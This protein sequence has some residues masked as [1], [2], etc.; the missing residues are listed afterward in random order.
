MSEKKKI[1][2]IVGTMQMGGQ[3]TFIMNIFR[4]IDREKYEFGFVVHS[5]E[6]AY[7]ED[8]VEKL[9][10]KIYRI[11]SISK[12]PIKHAMQLRTIINQN[13]F[14]IMHRHT[15]TSIVFI[16]LLIGRLCRMKKVI[17]HSHSNVSSKFKTIHKIFR[18]LLNIFAT[19]KL[20]CSKEAGYWLYGK[21]QKFIIVP[22]S[23]DIDKFKYNEEKRM[24]IRKE[25]NC[26]NKI[27]LGHIGRFDKIKN[28]TFLV[29][30]FE[31]IVEKNKN[32]ELWFLGNGEEKENIEK[33]C[34]EKNIIDSVKF[35]GTVKDTYNFLQGMDLFVFPS[36]KEGLGIALI[37]AQV[38]G[39][40]CVVSDTIQKEAIISKNVIQLSIET[41]PE[42]WAEIILEEIEKSKNRKREIEKVVFKKYDI[43]ELVSKIE[44]IYY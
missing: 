3:E 42:K 17:V 2:H 10:G 34:K 43:K 27:V 22:N 5:D 18:P 14:E 39:L 40:T 26:L 28:Q 30:I 38:A 33:K 13:N 4:N 11:K 23:I 12:N 31:K 21:R 44:E 15:N 16:D 7:Y 24:L 41:K 36:I 25:N 19:E 20:A 6:K 32:V 37:E 1:L 9:G 29:D 8:E 35:F